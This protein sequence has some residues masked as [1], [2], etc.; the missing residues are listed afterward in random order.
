MPRHKTPS[1][2]ILV[3]GGTGFLGK[4][5]VEELLQR[6]EKQIRVLTTSPPEWL[7]TLDVEVVEGSVTSAEI[8]KVAVE[9]VQQIYHLAGRVSRNDEEKREMYAV[10]VDGTRILC[11]AAIK[12]G[13]RRMVLA[14]SSGTIA[15]TEDGFEIP[16]EEWPTPIEIISKFPYYA[17]KLYQEKTARMIC[18]NHMELVILNPSLLLG[19][20]DERLSSTQDVLKFLA[21]DIP[22]TPSGG[23]NFVDVRDVAPAFYNAMQHGIPGERYLLAGPNWTL[24][25]FFGHLERVSKVSAPRL[26]IPARLHTVSS[27]IVEGAYK[28]VGKT[29][30]VEPVSMEMSR[31]FWYA[32][33]TKAKEE[34]G[35]SPRDPQETLHDTVQYLRTQFLGAG[36]FN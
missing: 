34:L 12:A 4:H 35:F 23:M 21:G 11:E 10:H 20:G 18:K 27:K 14:S 22:A 25:R 28:T 5:L 19:P 15:I 8:V 24:E 33:S 9:G 16:N 17:S 31:Y 26:K 29:P 7:Q 36:I 13:A 2:K 1:S 32:D 3:T 6:G 30:P